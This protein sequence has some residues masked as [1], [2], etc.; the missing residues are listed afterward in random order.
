[1]AIS[2]APVGA[3]WVQPSETSVAKDGVFFINGITSKRIRQDV[4]SY[5]A[6]NLIVIVNNTTEPIE[7]FPDGD[8]SKGLFISENGGSRVIEP[9]DGIKAVSFVCYN[10]GAN[11]INPSDTDVGVKT[12][13]MRVKE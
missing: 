5:G 9:S 7:C 10:R 2:T 6:F 11:I 3:S 4:D 8:K 12:L 13:F 1:M